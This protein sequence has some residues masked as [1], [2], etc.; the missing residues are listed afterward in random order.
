MVPAE[1]SAL[2]D[3]RV[4]VNTDPKEFEKM[5]VQWIYEA[6]ADETDSGR[7][8]YQFVHVNLIISLI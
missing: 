7:I 1:F 4:S 5:I 3:L 2:F 6:E 8:S